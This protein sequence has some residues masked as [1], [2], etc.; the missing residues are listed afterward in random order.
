[1]KL[2]PKTSKSVKSLIVELAL[3]WYGVYWLMKC[4]EIWTFSIGMVEILKL[5]NILRAKFSAPDADF[6]KIL[7]KLIL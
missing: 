2:G 6:W 1:M 5:C 3:L 4:H 7:N